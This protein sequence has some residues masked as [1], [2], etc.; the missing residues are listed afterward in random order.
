M[1]FVYAATPHS[2]SLET[3]ILLVPVEIIHPSETGPLNLSSLSSLPVHLVLFSFTKDMNLSSFLEPVL[4]LPWIW[5][6]WDQSKRDPRAWT[7]LGRPVSCSDTA[8]IYLSEVGERCEL[9]GLTFS[10][11]RMRGL[12]WIVALTLS[13]WFFSC[14]FSH[15]PQLT[16]RG[17]LQFTKLS[18][19]CSL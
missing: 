7:R 1:C 4:I 10:T 3:P 17:A 8:T 16:S 12:V 5:C 15:C 9:P 14:S 19:L 11:V 13:F 18:Y 2:G 6:L